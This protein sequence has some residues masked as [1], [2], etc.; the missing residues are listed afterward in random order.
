MSR[1]QSS[2]PNVSKLVLT[3]KLW[4]VAIPLLFA[5]ILMVYLGLSAEFPVILSWALVSTLA[6]HSLC[7][8]HYLL[9]DKNKGTLTR[10]LSSLFPIA[11]LEL[12]LEHIAGFCVTKSFLERHE[13][14]LVVMMNDGQRVSLLCNRALSEMEEHGQYLA[15]FCRR[16]FKLEISQ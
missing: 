8:R 16:P 9:V 6:L 11:R 15:R 4:I 3:R 12:P 7:V 5:S 1:W 13:F 2:S 10:H 14:N